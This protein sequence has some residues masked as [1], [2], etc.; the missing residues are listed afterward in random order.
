MKRFGFTIIELLVV[1]VIVVLLI[2]F[3][4]LFW[5]IQT[6]FYL[7]F[8]W[9]WGLGRFV[10]GLSHEPFA[11]LLGLVAVLLLPVAFHLFAAPLVKRHG[12]KLLFRQS[13]SVSIILVFVAAAGIAMVAGVHDVLWLFGSKEIIVKEGSSLM[14]ARRMQSRTYLAHLSLHIQ[15]FHDANE[16]LPTGGTVL[17]DGRLG[18]GWMAQL[19]PYTEQQKTYDNI[20]FTKPW[21]DP[22]NA[23]IFKKLPGREFCSPFLNRSSQE[24]QADQNGFAYTDYAA[25]QLV[26]PFGRSLAYDDITDGQSNTL[27]LGEVNENFQ[28]WG[29][30]LNGRDPRLGVNQSP[31]GFGSKSV[32][33]VQFSL[34]DGSVRF[35]S[36]TIDPKILGALATPNGGDKAH[37]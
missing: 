30:P 3:I 5:I 7:L 27:L 1:I 15:K 10:A 29:S 13:V 37:P 34:C 32:G 36:D 18:H 2:A 17:S 35:I 31:Y 4:N 20:D 24:E 28:P 19:L 8:G 21:N 9:I 6:P 25:N 33:G 26:M 22:D 16:H 11:V 14:I 23:D 12:S